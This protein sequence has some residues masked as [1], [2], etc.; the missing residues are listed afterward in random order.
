MSIY[1]VAI[2]IKPSQ[3]L[4]FRTLPKRHVHEHAQISVLTSGIVALGL[5]T[6]VWPAGRRV[7]RARPSRH[8]DDEIK[9]PSYRYMYPRTASYSSR[10]LLNSGFKDSHCKVQIRG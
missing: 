6:W 4:H 2:T 1:F 8:G 10:T 9:R 5:E 3:R 7:A